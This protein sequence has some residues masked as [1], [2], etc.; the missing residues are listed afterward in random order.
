MSDE[1][2]ITR[3][4]QPKE[5]SPQPTY[6]TERIDLPSKGYFY[7]DNDPLSTGYVDMKMMT[8]KEEDILTSQNL[9]KKGIVLDKLL[10]SLI[11]TPGVNIDNLLLCDKNALFVA[12]RRLAY[13]DS[14][15]PVQI[16]CQKC[17]EEN[18]ETI[19]LGE[20]KEKPYEFDKISKSSNTFEFVLPY[21]KK[22]VIFK[23]LSSKDEIDIDNELKAT[24]KFVKS[25]GSTE[26]TT[27]LKKMILAIDGKNDRGLINKYIDSEMVSKDSMALRAYART[28]TPEL[29]MSFNF[30]CPSCSHEERMDVPMTVQFFW[31]ES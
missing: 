19:N 30:T 26:I 31:P 21:S 1:I 14:Y 2:I 22:T 13:G 29:D 7:A 6:P 4:N 28:V 23:L 24:A 9:I 20:L 3:G 25:G 15:G 11:V 5:Q 17:Y 27:R 18:K 16:R 8:A 12:A 10:E